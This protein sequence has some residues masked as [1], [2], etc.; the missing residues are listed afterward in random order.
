[1][2]AWLRIVGLLVLSAALTAP[3]AAQPAIE[4]VPAA[5][6]A[7]EVSFAIAVP[8]FM[9]EIRVR[10]P[11]SDPAA[12]QR[13]TTGGLFIRVGDGASVPA[14]WV[15]KTPA[16]DPARLASGTEASFMVSA[17]LPGPGVY[18]SWIEAA[19]A[20]GTAGVPQR[21]RVVVT[22]AAQTL[23]TDFLVAPLASPVDLDFLPTLGRL[24][25]RGEAMPRRVLLSLRNSTV[26]PVEFLPPLVVSY[27]V[28][29]GAVTSAVASTDPPRIDPGSCAASLAPGA[30][31]TLSL[32]LDRNAWFGQYD[33]RVG[34]AGVGGGWSE[35][36][37]AVNVRASAGLAFL[38]I[39]AGALAGLVVNGWRGAGRRA[40]TGLIDLGHIRD[41]INRIAIESADT[42]TERVRASLLARA[43]EVESRFRSGADAGADLA[44][45]AQRAAVLPRLAALGR[46]LAG[47][48]EVGRT[49]LAPRFAAIA[50]A[51]ETAEGDA[52]AA[53]DRDLVSLAAAFQAWPA[54]AAE[55]RVA[56]R[57]AEGV[58]AAIGAGAGA[59]ASDGRAILEPLVAAA[60]AALAP[61]EA[62]TTVETRR[63]ALAIVVAGAREQ[64][65]AFAASAIARLNEQVKALLA[66]AEAD[67]TPEVAPARALAQ[68]TAALAAARVTPEGAEAALAGYVAASGKRAALDL[69]AGPSALAT[70]A[71]ASVL[72]RAEWA[73][74]LS[75]PVL[76]AIFAM[77]PLSAGAFLPP[78]DTSLAGLQRRKARY[79]WLTSA[80][81]LGALGLGGVS[82]LWASDP[83][84]GSGLS[85]ITAFLAG[86]AVNVAVG[87]VTARP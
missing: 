16:V 43:D 45:L 50:A 44:P 85:L 76:D 70:G 56:A 15:R 4:L 69:A 13:L 8:G 58:N 39:V 29:A 81:V 47:L 7:T 53:A 27:G 3:I 2:R 73:G 52:L 37:Q 40:L 24:V 25:G 17:D 57:L 64:A 11:A 31:C 75:I 9:E 65:A 20:S 77:E 28:R 84:W 71:D 42:E 74:S 55:A 79:E 33:I 67:R 54:L 35:Q 48:P 23:P 63:Q 46:A 32:L 51:I 36:T 61:F 38:V 18:Q 68:T 10:N 59:G 21:I 19:P 41:V 82:T 14:R 1:M 22:R 80:I 62:G 49:A 5:S 66:T 30:N 26:N 6:P 78:P 60:T 72:H 86:L 34:V 87:S 12:V 83:A